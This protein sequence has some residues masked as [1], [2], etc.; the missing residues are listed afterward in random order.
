[1]TGRKRVWAALRGGPLNRP[2]KGEILITPGI[3]K[4]F[5]RPDLE[6]VLDYLNADLVVLPADEDA[7]GPLT[8]A[9]PD[10]K[11]W[12]RTSYF[13]FGLLQGPVTFLSEKMGWHKFSRMLIKNPGEAREIIDNYFTEKIRPVAAALEDGCD[14]IIVADDL[15]GDR[16][17]LIA[18]AFLKKNYFPPLAQLLHKIGVSHL[19]WIFHS[20]GNIPELISPL[21][22]AGFW[23]LH[24]L[25]PSVG[26]NPAGFTGRGLEKWVFWGN[27]EFEGPRRLKDAV[28]T[29]AEV[30]RLL[31]GWAGFPGY[32]FGSS[33]GLYDGLS[34]EAIKAAYE[35]VDNWGH[36][37]NA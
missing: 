1:M 20:D 30:G 12:A 25:Q 34:P 22:E 36:I 31:T 16:G 27:F 3:V 28:E 15:A 24:G 21:R 10:W 26:L 9:L 23:G 33:G 7:A 14:G 18:P 2:P 8:G 19:P 17:L 6:S 37:E 29:E 5:H 11:S 35:T 32:I 13:V 4:A